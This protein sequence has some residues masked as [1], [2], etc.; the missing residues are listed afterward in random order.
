MKARNRS[1]RVSKVISPS[2][3]LYLRL[4]LGDLAL[5]PLGTPYRLGGQ[6]HLVG[7]ERLG[8]IIHRAVAH[9]L[10]RTLNGGIGGDHDDAH[11]RGSPSEDLR[12]RGEP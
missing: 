5:Q 2:A 9:G 6:A 1:L 3:S 11:P 4:Q 7:G 8:Q 10:D 12:Q